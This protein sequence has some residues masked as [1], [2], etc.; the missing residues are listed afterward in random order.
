MLCC[1]AVSL[2]F[3]MLFGVACYNTFSWYFLALF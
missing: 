3:I 2:G 1:Y